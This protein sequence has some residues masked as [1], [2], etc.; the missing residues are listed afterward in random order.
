MN[1]ALLVSN[2][3]LWGVVLALVVVVLAL[4]RQIGILYE[5]VAPMGALMM[6]QGPKVGEVAP[7]FT[8]DSIGGGKL[9]VGGNTGRSQL[10]FFLSPTCPVC[11]K[12]LPVLKSIQGAEKGWLDVALAS[13]GDLP[14]HA[15]FYRKA[16]LKSFPYALSTDLG[17]TYR[18][19]KLPYAVLIG[20]DGRIRG[21]GLV[22]SREQLESL[23]AA[24]EAGVAS[25]Q[26]FIDQRA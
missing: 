15:E 2:V 18:I 16:D 26:E 24:K 12:L 10:L 1:E 14:E 20:E 21:K 5:R 11:K 6:D 25:I 3:F 9:S 13:D 8:L 22:N 7:A 23:F 17:M 19:A 4:A